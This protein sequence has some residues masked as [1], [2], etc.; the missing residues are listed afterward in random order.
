MSELTDFRAEKDEVFRDDY[1]SPLTAEQQADFTGLNYY[2]ENPSLD[3]TATLEPFSAFEP[4]QMITSKGS[5]QAFNRVGRLHFTVD[6]VEQALTLYQDAGGQYLF[7]PFT[8]ATSGDETYD[9]GRYVEVE[10]AGMEDEVQLVRIDF[11]RA[12]NPYCAYNEDWVCPVPPAENRLSVSIRAG[13]KKF[14]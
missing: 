7:L 3:V 10:S 9:A 2:P 4:V 14:H 1:Q 6:G 11:N 8:D 5:I 13:E 12:Y